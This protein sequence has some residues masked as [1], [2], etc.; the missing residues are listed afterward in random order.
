MHLHVH[1]Y[2]QVSHLDTELK[3]E[4]EKVA[5]MMRD[6]SVSPESSSTI[7]LKLSQELDIVKARLA[8]E[9]E[10]KAALEEK[11]SSLVV[12]GKGDGARRNLVI[13]E[14]QEKVSQLEKAL[15]E[16]ESESKKQT[17][18]HS[19]TIAD[20]Q[21]KLSRERQQRQEILQSTGTK[22]TPTS[23]EASAIS[24]DSAAMTE[25]LREKDRTIQHLSAQLQKFE[26]TARDVMKITQH[27]KQQSGTIVALKEEL[28]RMQVHIHVHYT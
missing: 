25:A 17:Q 24:P 14:L 23:S 16:K 15:Q 21:T 18:V 1:L 20:L 27:S 28:E 11:L 2:M 7:S 12:P 19:R 26:K 5:K 4:K 6:R 3:E 10:A 22:P 13:S 9:V 8:Y